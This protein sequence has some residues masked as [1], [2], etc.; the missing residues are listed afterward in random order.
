MARLLQRPVGRP[1]R[2]WLTEALLI[3]AILVFGGFALLAD[4]R[5]SP[6][7]LLSGLNTFVAR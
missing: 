5:L 4:A 6:S 1:R 2:L 7:E 3:A